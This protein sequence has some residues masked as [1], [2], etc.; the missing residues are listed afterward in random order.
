MGRSLAQDRQ[1][2][3]KTKA[4]PGQG[5]KAR[6][7]R[8]SSPSSCARPR[9]RSSIPGTR[10]GCAA[11]T[12]TISRRTALN[13]SEAARRFPDA[14]HDI[15]E[16]SA[17]GVA[18]R[19]KLLHIVEHRIGRFLPDSRREGIAPQLLHVLLVGSNVSNH[20]STCASKSKPWTSMACAWS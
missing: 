12:A 1:Q 4:R 11:P 20:A 16:T 18:C 5:D 7:D 17:E 3:A 9:S 14:C 19:P 10:S 13:A 15:V 6:P 8:I 2:R